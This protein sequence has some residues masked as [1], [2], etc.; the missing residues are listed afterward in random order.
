MAELS[1]QHLVS[2]TARLTGAFVRFLGLGFGVALLGTSVTGIGLGRLIRGGWRRQL[3]RMVRDGRSPARARRVA[4]IR[5]TIGIA[6]TVSLLAGIAYVALD[7]IY[8]GLN[9]QPTPGLAQ[10]DGAYRSLAA[11][12][13]PALA[14]RYFELPAPATSTTA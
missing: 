14:A 3:A 6:L 10:P 8:L 11:F 7:R 12:E 1:T 9:G 13:Q 5:S 2:G 4:T